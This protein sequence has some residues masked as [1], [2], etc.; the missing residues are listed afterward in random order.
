[1]RTYQVVEASQT[2]A[3]IGEN[4]GSKYDRMEGLLVIPGTTSPGAVTLIDA[5]DDSPAT[6]ASFVAF[7]GGASSVSNLVPFFIPI[8]A[9]S[10]NGGWKVTTGGNVRVVAVGN[11]A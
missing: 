6:S 1:M 11:F 4:G 3:N 7:T 8:G 2:E 5:S 10:K 9:N